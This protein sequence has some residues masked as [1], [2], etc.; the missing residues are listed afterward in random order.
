MNH[1][2]D[3]DFQI[4]VGVSVKTEFSMIV[5]IHSGYTISIHD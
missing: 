1:K 2:N 5:K 3:A 4:M